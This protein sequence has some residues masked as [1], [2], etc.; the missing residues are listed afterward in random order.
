MNDQPQHA[1]EALYA[2]LLADY[3]TMPEGPTKE[4]CNEIL[5][6]IEAS[7]EVE[8]MAIDAGMSP[9]EFDVMF[10][11]IAQEEL[12]KLGYDDWPR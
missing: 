2:K 4:A 11:R 7:L 1:G 12:R 8:R 9:D 10:A 5:H 6:Q 3:A